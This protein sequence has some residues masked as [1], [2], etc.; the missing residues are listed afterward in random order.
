VIE[1]H[2]TDRGRRR[3]RPVTVDLAELRERLADPFGRDEADW[4]AIRA[5]LAS[6]MSSDQFE[7]W[8][9]P[10]ALIAVDASGVLLLGCPPDTRSWVQGRF[11]PLLNRA[12]GSVGRELRL[13][14]DA[15]VAAVSLSPA[16][17]PGE[18]AE[19]RSVP[20][21]PSSL[22]YDHQEAL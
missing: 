5:E 20:S 3:R 13:A 21:P 6:R 10:L 12:A 18:R 1:E 8:L 9:G 2:I 16:A 22:I 17:S 11:G 4:A 15:E 14:S 7:I 19:L